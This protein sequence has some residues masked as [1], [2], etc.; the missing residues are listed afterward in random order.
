[1]ILVEKENWSLGAKMMALK[2]CTSDKPKPK[3][4]C[5]PPILYEMCIM[6]EHNLYAFINWTKM[7]CPFGLFNFLNTLIVHKFMIASTFIENSIGLKR[8]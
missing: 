4:F 7:K 1:M 2:T 3:Q 8:F 5:M 6:T